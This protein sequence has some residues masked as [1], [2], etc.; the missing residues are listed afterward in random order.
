MF[1]SRCAQGKSMF[2]NAQILGD[3]FNPVSMNVQGIARS[4]ASK[5]PHFTM[6]PNSL[7]GRVEPWNVV[8]IYWDT[9][10]TVDEK[11]GN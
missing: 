9:G 11:R 4:T 5:I 7:I 1:L 2:K 10:A 6:L 3:R 8:P